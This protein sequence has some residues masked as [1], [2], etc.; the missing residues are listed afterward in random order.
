MPGEHL[1]TLVNNTCHIGDGLGDGLVSG[2][3]HHV[4]ILDLYAQSAGSGQ[5]VTGDG[6]VGCF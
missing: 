5:R 1:T 2:C 6:C 4:N 3:F